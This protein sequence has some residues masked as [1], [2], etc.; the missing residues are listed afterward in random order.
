MLETILAVASGVGTLATSTNSVIEVIQKL[1][2]LLKKAEHTPQA[3]QATPEVYARWSPPPMQP[4][5]PRV[6]DPF[7]GGNQ[8]IP[9]LQSV[10]G[11][12]GN[13][14]V[15]TQTY[16][17]LGVD[18][19]GLWSPPMNMYD[20]TYIRQF[21]PYLNVIAGVGGM[22]TLYAEGV[23]DPSHSAIHVVGSYVNGAPMEGHAQLYPN[24][25]LYGVMTTIG[26]FGQ[27]MQ[28]PTNMVKIG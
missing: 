10:A 19:T 6:Q 23:F 5:Q 9:Q 1:K 4:F 12:F 22:P 14:W 7:A 16:G 2:G 15:P 20:Q 27:P 8:W 13:P 25:V 17:L 26:P 24:W 18:L 3:L 11:Q 28:V 21:G